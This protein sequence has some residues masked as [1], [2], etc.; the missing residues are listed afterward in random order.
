MLNL[1]Q[2]TSTNIRASCPVRPGGG[3]PGPKSARE[4]AL[5]LR[6]PIWASGPSNCL[7]IKFQSPPAIIQSGLGDLGFQ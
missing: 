3:G 7:W 5:G 4:P 6:G 1:F 2:D